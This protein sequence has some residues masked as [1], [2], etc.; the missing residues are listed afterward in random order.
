MPMKASDEI[1]R[2][3]PPRRTMRQG[4]RPLPA[5]A[6]CFTGSEHDVP[7]RVGEFSDMRK[8]LYASRALPRHPAASV[9]SLR[10]SRERARTLT[11]AEKPPNHALLQPMLISRP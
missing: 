2:T 1:T 7:E 4:R 9:N 11:E 3:M 5:S 6:E 8:I 10:G